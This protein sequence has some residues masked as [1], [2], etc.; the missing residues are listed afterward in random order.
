MCAPG[1]HDH[2][3]H[4]HYGNNTQPSGANSSSLGNRLDR[5]RRLATSTT[6][7]GTFQGKTVLQGVPRNSGVDAIRK[8]T[9]T[10]V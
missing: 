4:R 7:G 2:Q 6:G 10:G 3:S 8:T 1:V 5:A 9:F